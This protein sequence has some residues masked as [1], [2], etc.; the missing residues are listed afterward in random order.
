MS[1]IYYVEAADVLRAAGVQV[2]ENSI[3]AGWQER[4]RSSG[5]FA[6]P[7]LGTCWHHTA[8]SASVN[9]DLGYMID[10]SDDAPIGNMLLDRDGVVWLIAAGAA[11]TQG[12]GGPHTFS[13]GTVPLDS[14]NSRCWGIEVANNGVGETWPQVQIDAYFAASNALSEMFGNLPTDLMTH[15]EWA[16][17]RKIDPAKANAIEG[18]WQPMAVTTSGTWDGDA[19][20]A[21]CQRRAIGTTPTPPTPPITPIEDD[22]AAFLLRNR[23]TGQIVLLAYDGAGVTATGMSGDDLD[24]YVGKF[25]GWLDTDP[26]VFDDFINKSNG[27]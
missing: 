3:N 18:P 9:S 7:P 4:A 25:G 26:A 24:G 19:I 6:E 12:K 27:G 17:D 8:S 11:N 10:G 23:D 15:H 5:G 22:M 13:R 16:E 2:G 21:E 20:R 14:G 1:G